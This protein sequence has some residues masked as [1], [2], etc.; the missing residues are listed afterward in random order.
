M[1]IKCLAIVANGSEDSE[2][3]TCT[4]L[5][6]RAGGEYKYCSLDEIEVTLSHGSK[7]VCDFLF[8][9]S[10][11]YEDY[12]LIFIPGGLKGV[13]RMYES[14]ALLKLIKNFHDTN[15]FIS[16]ICAGPT[17]LALA[18]IMENH[19]FTCYDGF[20]EK[21]NVKDNYILKAPSVVSG[22]VITGRS[23]NYVIE[24]TLDIIETMLGK[25]KRLALEKQI[26][27]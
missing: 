5:I 11:N 2:L 14:N 13:N 12:N 6:K 1:N 15:R 27:R 22:N 18:Q 20:E 21:T 25:D 8:D 19:K 26:L 9:E 10:S 7:L 3:I 23:V 17:V 24:F 4:D 16:A